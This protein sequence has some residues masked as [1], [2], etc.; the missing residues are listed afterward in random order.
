[1]GQL[2]RSA[3]HFEDALA[4]CKRAGYHPELAWTCYDCA[5]A[6]LERNGRGDPERA[7][8]LMEEGLSI[9]HVLGLYHLT[10]KLVALPPLAQPA[11]AH[12]H[13]PEYLDG[14]TEREVEVLRLVTVG[15]SNHEIGNELV[16]SI[17]TV[18][19]HITN[20]YAKIHA[21]GRADATANAFSHGLA[22]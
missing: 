9:A 7:T 6:L 21:R 17:P 13:P 5:D 2:D 15:K 10:Q 19:R 3:N 8:S 18:E 1:M 16:L 4:F 12:P 14:L 20:I 11:S 22:G